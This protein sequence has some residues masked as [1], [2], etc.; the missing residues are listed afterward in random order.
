MASLTYDSRQ[1]KLHQHLTPPARSRLWGSQ[2]L[3]DEQDGQCHHDLS[4]IEPQDFIYVLM[5]GRVVEQ[6][7]RYSL[8]WARSTRA[9]ASSERLAALF[10]YMLLFYMNTF[11]SGTD[12]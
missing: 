1:M 7:C 8:K 11:H 12:L 10:V 9:E 6:G 4:Q 3:V 2:T 5:Q